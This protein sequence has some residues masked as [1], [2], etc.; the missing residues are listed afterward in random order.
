ML[1]N[2]V[3]LYF[4]D[5]ARVFPLYESA[6]AGADVLFECNSSTEVT[7]YYEGKG[8]PYNARWFGDNSL[9][10]YDVEDFNAGQYECLGR[11]ENSAIFYGIVLL[12]V[13]GETA[14]PGRVRIL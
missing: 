7:W 8:I 9:V 14:V 4:I 10:I 13:Y 5:N 6:R 2:C 1:H 12:N 11:N 3:L